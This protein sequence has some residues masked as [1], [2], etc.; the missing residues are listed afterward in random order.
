[1]QRKRNTL[2][3]VRYAQRTTKQCCR[4]KQKSTGST[5]HC[6][7]YMADSSAI[8]LQYSLSLLD[9][10]RKASNEAYATTL[11]GWEEIPIK[12]QVGT[13]RQVNCIPKRGKA[14]PSSYHN[15]F[16]SI[17]KTN[18]IWRISMSHSK[19]CNIKRVYKTIKP[20][21]RFLC[22]KDDSKINT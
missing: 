4:S 3:K 17:S 19:K 2:H 13:K 15:P 1:M 12:F 18:G 20:K 8:T 14:K 9:R 10:R 16:T 5:I 21:P 11:P 22:N 7:T 6:N